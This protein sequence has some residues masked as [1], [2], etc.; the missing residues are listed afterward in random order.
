MKRII[1]VLS[2]LIIVF[3]S[4]CHLQDIPEALPQNPESE[5]TKN[6][7][8]ES[9]YSSP[10]IYIGVRSLDQL[11]EM[12]SMIDEK[13]DQKLNL[14]LLSVEG[15]GA[16]NREDLISFIN[17]ID[18]IPIIKLIDGEI[19]W[20]AHYYNVSVPDEKK[21]GT[22]YVS[23]LSDNGDWTRIEY[24]LYE[25]DVETEIE[26]M[27]S[28]ENG[29]TDL[30][31]SNDGKINVYYQTKQAHTSGTGDIYE[32]I[33]S[34]DDKIAHVIYYTSN[35]NETAAFDMFDG[36]KITCLNPS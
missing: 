7:N 35:S 15:G 17:L 19:I 5:N 36:I 13:D 34:I 10:H 1:L 23:T 28:K 12:R 9:D 26:L 33:A 2:V 14:Y 18:S 27:Q 30:F 11:D 31:I 22:L 24:K 4:A 32:W 20:I 8:I 6:E 21:N 25:T 3:L 29:K 16:K